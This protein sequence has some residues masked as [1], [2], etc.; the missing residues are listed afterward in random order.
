MPCGS[1]YHHGCLRAGHPFQTR[2]RDRGG[3][4]YPSVE[5]VPNFICEACTV[6]AVLGRELGTG[7]HD[8][9]LLLLERMR[10]IDIANR[11]AKNTFARYTYAIRRIR[12]FEKRFGVTILRPTKLLA[13]PVTAAIPLQWAHQDYTL[14]KPKSGRN[15]DP[16]R[17]AANSARVLRSATAHYYDL[18]LHVSHPGQAISTNRRTLLVDPVTSAGEMSYNLMTSGMS[19]R[20]GTTSTPPTALTG[21]MI[22]FM[23][24]HYSTLWAGTQCP[25][26]RHEIATAALV[27]L[28]AWT[29]WARSN[30]LFS[31]RRE[32]VDIIL[33]SQG[34]TFGL[35]QHVGAVLVTLQESTKGDQ[36]RKCD[37]PVAF[38]CGSGLS[39]GKWLQRLETCKS[40]ICP[41]G[42]FL[43]QD[44]AGKRWDSAFYRDRHLIPLLDLCR[45]SGK[46]PQLAPSD[47]SPGNRLKDKFYSMGC[48]RRG[49]QS[50][51]THRRKAS[52]RIATQAESYEHGRWKYIG[53]N[54]AMPVHYTEWT[55]ADRIMITLFCM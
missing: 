44:P 53:R 19:K 7:S 37:I 45:L 18:D 34:P 3:L 21:T 23:E 6:R 26:L 5:Y 33:P 20:L 43:F 41:H 32:D 40:I 29:S 8:M 48:Y 24:D 14:H 15:K 4:T 17:V 52:I 1:L 31:L 30:E 36:T 12:K 38:V 54:E 46:E 11:W 10:M 22:Q 51:V 42:E 39:P 27:N 2:L 55:L 13:P 47:G 49:G 35:P 50:S 9:G 16:D 25:T 28:L